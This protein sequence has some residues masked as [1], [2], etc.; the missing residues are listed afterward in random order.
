M[1]SLRPTSAPFYSKNISITLAPSKRPGFSPA[2]VNKAN[3]ISSLH[4]ALRQKCR[5]EIILALLLQGKQPDPNNPSHQTPIHFMLAQ[6]ANWKDLQAFLYLLKAEK[7]PSDLTS[8]IESLEKFQGVSDED[9][10]N[11][12]IA[13]NIH[14]QKYSAGDSLLHFAI[15]QNSISLEVIQMFIDAGMDPHLANDESKTPLQL[16]IELGRSPEIILVLQIG[17]DDVPELRSSSP[18][19][20]YDFHK[21]LQK[22]RTD[23]ERRY[24]ELPE[25][26]AKLEMDR[27]SSGVYTNTKDTLQSPAHFAIAKKLDPKHTGPMDIKALLGTVENINRQYNGLRDT[28]LHF[29]MKQ[30]DCSLEIIEDLFDAG[31]DPFFFNIYSQTPLHFISQQCNVNITQLFIDKMKGPQK[32]ADQPYIETELIN[33]QDYWG[34]TALHYYLIESNY[35]L[36]R[37]LSLLLNAGASLHLPNKNKQTPFQLLLEKLDLDTARKLLKDN[38]D[39]NRKDKSLGNTPLHNAIESPNCT[40]EIIKKLLS[41]GADPDLPNGKGKSALQLAAEKQLDSDII[42]ELQL[43][44]DKPDPNNPSHQTPVHFALANKTSTAEDIEALLYM[45]KARNMIVSMHEEQSVENLKIGDINYQ[46]VGGNTLTHFALEIGCSKEIIQVLINQKPDLGI[47]NNNGETPMNLILEKWP[48][49]AAAE[50]SRENETNIGDQVI[51]DPVTDVQDE[52][53]NTSFHKATQSSNGVSETIKNFLQFLDSKAN[54]YLPNNNSQ[55]PLQLVLEKLSSLDIIQDLSEKNRVNINHQDD[56]LRNTPLYNAI[57][58]PDCESKTIKKYLSLK[59]DPY[60]PNKAGQSAL[61][62]AA[63][64]QLPSDIILDLQLKGNKPDPKNPSHQTPVHFALADEQSTVED[65]QALLYTVE[66]NINQKYRGDD[67]LLQFAIKKASRMEKINILLNTPSIIFK[68]S[69]KNL[70]LLRKVI[71]NKDQK[72]LAQALRK[73]I[74]SR[75]FFGFNWFIKLSIW[76]FSF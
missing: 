34:N 74:E 54:P 17:K 21:K 4:T 75:G 16:A 67:T 31:A 53:G 63:Q 1:N 22:E 39:I 42:L 69:I 48:T 37:T 62:L 57:Q 12:E 59:A 35:E 13:E 66:G 46:Y 44:G 3:S 15:K 18:S 45:V 5:S 24:Q 33:H 29:T 41:L 11:I 58:S 71:R 47:A 27:R 14:K 43:K 25:I 8:S 20:I 49:Y 72:D 55:T 19:R 68:F 56:L 32:D 61:Q 9:T 64:K 40:L 7:S 10:Q 60:L 50:L 26:A 28:L 73:K 30:K 52:E 51:D 38:K 23:Q 70:L 6:G 36:E 2:P 76:C 65:V